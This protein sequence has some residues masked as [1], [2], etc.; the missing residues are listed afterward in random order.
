MWGVD[1]RQHGGQPTRP[2]PP[3]G[4]ASPRVLPLRPLDTVLGGVSTHSMAQVVAANPISSL[5]P[6]V[7]VITFSDA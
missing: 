4:F 1:W 5:C 2:V 7:I 3:R 6:R